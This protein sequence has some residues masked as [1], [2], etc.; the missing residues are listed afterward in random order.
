MKR[1][2]KSKQKKSCIFADKCPAARKKRPYSFFSPPLWLP[3]R[4]EMMII[5]F[6][7]KQK[8][9]DH[10][11]ANHPRKQTI[12]NNLKCM[13][14]PFSLQNQPHSRYWSIQ[15]CIFFS[16]TF[17]ATIYAANFVIIFCSL[18]FGYRQ[19]NNVAKKW[20]HSFILSVFFYSLMLCLHA[21]S[22]IWLW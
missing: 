13:Y 17:F 15:N 20:I 9:N 5:F 12:F 7:A 16:R 19:M 4:S 11:E 18:L 14:V 3:K 21:I 2:W 8:P 22:G 10:G 1:M 6:W